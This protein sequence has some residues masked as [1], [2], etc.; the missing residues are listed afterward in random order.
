MK[1]TE[2]ALCYK[3]SAIYAHTADG[4]G[5]PGRI[6]GE[7][8]II[9]RCAKETNHTKLHYKLIHHFLYFFLGNQP[10]FQISLI[11]DVQERAD[12]SKTHCRAILLLDRAKICKIGP[13]GCFQGVF[14]RLAD[15]IAIGG[16]HF[17]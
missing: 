1:D 11:I 3:R 16:R 5:N 12:S 15:I 6:P 4:L 13:L 14:R 7:K 17:L 9:F 8:V 10:I 2:A